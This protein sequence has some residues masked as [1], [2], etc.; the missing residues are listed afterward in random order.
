MKRSTKPI[1][2]RRR[3]GP[4][5]GPALDPDYVEWLHERHCVVNGCPYRCVGAHTQNN[6]MRHRGPD[7]SRVPLCGG[8]GTNMHHEQYDGQCKLPNGEFGGHANFERYYDKDMR[9][10][11]AIHYALF[12]LLKDGQ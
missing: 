2:K 5:R 8:L 12:Q 3:G 10:E 9:R 1:P 4:R 11:A 6:G 7:S